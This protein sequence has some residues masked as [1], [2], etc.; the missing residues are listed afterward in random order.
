VTTVVFILAVAACIVG[1]IGTFVPALPGIPVIWA[2]MLVYGLVERFREITP[3]FLVITFLVVAGCQ[4]AEQYARAWGAR[5][6]GAGKAGAWGAVVGSIAGLFFMPI[7]LV[8]GPF[9]G[10]MLFELI[11]GRTTREAV[12]AGWG[13]L[14]G[15]LGSVAVNVVVGIGLTLAFVF[16]VL[17]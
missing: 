17:F 9:L 3:T 5:K 1:I 14:V 7:G 11:A 13:G 12:L 15:V 10:A 2:A 6:Y 4:V 16:K 8:V